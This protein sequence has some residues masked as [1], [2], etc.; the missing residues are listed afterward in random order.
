MKS[1][2]QIRIQ[3]VQSDPVVKWVAREAAKYIQLMTGRSP[4]M[5]PVT[6]TDDEDGCL[7]QIGTV[8]QFS[9]TWPDVT[10][11]GQDGFADGIFV[12]AGSGRVI[13]SGLNSR[14]VLFALY[15]WLEELGCRWLRPGPMG[16]MVP[17]IAD[18][19][20]KV[21]RLQE[22]PS[23]RHRCIC[24]EGSCSRQHVLD[25][26][27]YAAKRG[28]NAYF[29][30]F[31]NS[32]TFF[33]HWY[34]NERQA[35]GPPAAFS[36]EEAEAIHGEI[37]RAALDRG[38]LLHMVGHGWTCEPFGIKGTEWRPTTQVISDLIKRFFAQVGGRR[39][40]WGGIPLNTQLCYGN[41]VVR[42]KM[43]QAVA[44][45]AGT[46]PEEQVI[47]VWLADG[48]NN[49]CECAA[50]RR[51]RPSDLY[52]DLLNEID[53]RLA[54][55]RLKTR[56]VF[57]AY[58]D[59]LWAPI[60]AKIAN[61]DRFI[62]MFAPITRSYSRPFGGGTAVPSKPVGP[63]VRNKLVFPTSPEAN[64]G[65]LKGWRR[66]FKGECVDFD[67]HL[68]RDWVFD[69]GQMQISRVIYEDVRNLAPLGMNG[70]ISCQAQRL[71]FPTGLPLHLLGKT[72]WNAR[73]SFDDLVRNYFRDIY[74]RQ[75]TRVRRLMEEIS[76]RIDPSFLR[77]E[78]KRPADFR[79]AAQAYAELTVFVQRRVKGISIPPARDGSHIYS[80]RI[81]QH[82][83]WYITSLSALYAK[84]ASKDPTAGEDLAELE[85]GLKDRLMELHPVLDTWMVR[86]MLRHVVAS[87]GLPYRESVWVT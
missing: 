84:V 73:D 18:P 26:V 29:L 68:W 46:H 38:L 64:L 83:I 4:R 71:A 3:A 1:A 87:A 77:G 6:A 62:L 24:I 17:R 35:S 82:Y 37:K 40:L 69:P 9:G 31:R 32:Y 85:K 67:Y 33:D 52:V 76:Q 72:L 23:Y 22:T 47:H 42:D 10:A 13:L 48:S 20:R 74:G 55:R 2:S 7:I 58:V 51:H 28:F 66:A 11:T 27:D 21:V 53:R 15:R 12:K 16:E 14:S 30:Q 8:D 43:A 75:G 78:K 61:P 81:L 36:V 54:G 34:R 80:R 45:Y 19:L 79:R 50:C 65:M 5:I 57:L 60:R 86:A 39:E 44:E 70:Y 25:M 41:P 56:I 63:F 49:N 59:L